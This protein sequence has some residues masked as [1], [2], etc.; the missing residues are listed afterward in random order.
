M[1][2]CTLPNPSTASRRPAPTD[3]SPP[4]VP[5]RSRGAKTGTGPRGRG[6]PS[7]MDVEAVID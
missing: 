5:P 2:G 6:G 1:G 3:Q 7:G 4:A